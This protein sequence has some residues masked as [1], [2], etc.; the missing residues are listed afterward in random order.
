MREYW[1]LFFLNMKQQA[2]VVLFAVLS[3]SSTNRKSQ[4]GTSNFTMQQLQ[5]I[6]D[7]I[8]VTW[9]AAFPIHCNWE[10]AALLVKDPA[11][12]FLLAPPEHLRHASNSGFINAYRSRAVAFDLMLQFENENHQRFTHVLFARPD[13]MY[14][15]NPNIISTIGRCPDAVFCYNDFFGAMKRNLAPWYATHVATARSWT[16]ASQIVVNQGQT[17][18]RI[19]QL[20]GWNFTGGGILMPAM[21]LAIHGVPFAGK[22]LEVIANSQ[23]VMCNQSDVLGIAWIIREFRDLSPDVSAAVCVAQRELAGA[24]RSFGRMGMNASLQNSLG[25]CPKY[26]ASGMNQKLRET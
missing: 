5:R 13:I 8:N 16:G 4:T 10:E 2:E 15:L 7:G 11:L 23:S 24:L 26:S 17:S 6:L 12:R 9:R 19:Q 14:D 1:R 20:L 25:T 22:M 18:Q 3:R 21:H